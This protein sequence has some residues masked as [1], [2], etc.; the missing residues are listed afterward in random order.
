MWTARDPLE[1]LMLRRYWNA[2]QKTTD[3]CWASKT[4]RGTAS[5]QLPMNGNPQL[6]EA[7]I[8]QQLRLSLAKKSETIS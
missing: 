7:R 8:R 5:D 1:K 3:L 4:N 6:F 2:L